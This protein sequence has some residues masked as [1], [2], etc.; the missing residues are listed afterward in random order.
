MILYAAQGGA[1]KGRRR[2]KPRHFAMLAQG[3]ANGQARWARRLE[4]L[5]RGEWAL[6]IHAPGS[7]AL[8]RELADQH[9]AGLSV[10]DRLTVKERRAL[11]ERDGV[12]LLDLDWDPLLPT[13]DVVLGLIQSIERLGLPTSRIRVLHA[14]QAART[15]FEALWRRHS[16]LEPPATL[17]FPSSFALGLV[18]QHARRD[19][20][21]IEA[22]LKQARVR[23]E[24]PR[25]ER[26]FNLF[27]GGLR[28]HR[29]HV[30]AHLHHEGVLGEGWVSMLGYD[31][32]PGGTRRLKAGQAAPLPEELRHE[33]AKMSHPE[34]LGPSLEAVWRMTPMTL[35]LRH[36]FR[37]LGYERMVW[38]SQDTAYYDRSWFSA[39]TESHAN[40]AQMLHITEKV[41]KPMLNAHPFLY[42]GG[43]GGLKRLRIYGFET[44]APVFDESCDLHGEPRARIRTFLAELTRLAA[45]PQAEL[46][47]MCIELWPRCEHNYR[48]FWGAGLERLA[49]AFRAEVL[50]RLL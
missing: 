15:P 19:E 47:D 48:H 44:F 46:R 29:L 1:L 40:R 50:D 32:H 36:D 45:L 3:L 30:L 2:F 33:S 38:S 10:F 6:V 16:G 21:R 22:R 5:P 26:S 7:Y 34:S 39:V 41:M 18:W 9:L 42:L 11:E 37:L 4:E 49:G 8:N 13:A 43:K 20:A 27:N 31:K 28:P 23:L 17:E 14:N 25:L 12:L 35:D 24:R